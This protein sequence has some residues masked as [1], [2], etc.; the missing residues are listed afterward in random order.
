MSEIEI[1]SLESL[2]PAEQAEVVS[3]VVAYTSGKMGEQPQMLAVSEDNL[4]TKEV[5][6]GYSAGKFAGVIATAAA[7]NGMAEVGTLYVPED[8]R[9]K[10][11]ATELVKAATSSSL[12]KGVMPY[13]F[14]NPS[15]QPI[16][17]SVGYEITTMG[18]LP[19]RSNRAV[20]NL[21]N[22]T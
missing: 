6:V 12:G 1:K 18:K 11:Y 5:L 7:L 15:S 2:R 8:Q 21:P 16:F 19:P 13:A 22:A 17:E 4:R 10:S 14:T 3:H 9:G 20:L